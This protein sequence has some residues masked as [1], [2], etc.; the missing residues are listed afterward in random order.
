MEFLFKEAL[1]WPLSKAG[2]CSL[3]GGGFSSG[4]RWSKFAGWS[5]E[6]LASIVIAYWSANTLVAGMTTTNSAEKLFVGL[7]SGNV[8]FYTALILNRLL[9]R[10]TSFKRVF[11]E[12][13]K[14]FGW[15]EFYDWLPIRPL[16]IGV[17]AWV[18]QSESSGTT[19]GHLWA[20]GVFYYLGFS[21]TG[22]KLTEL[23]SLQAARLLH[24]IKA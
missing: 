7:I 23:S 11:L 13:V 6:N 15:P 10:R 21:G 4:T 12:T 14:E 17:C 18:L 2:L 3:P 5:K 20:D 16:L 1:W 19:W 22:H 24:A 8:V 9:I